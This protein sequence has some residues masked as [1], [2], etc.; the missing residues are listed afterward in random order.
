MECWSE[1]TLIC[2]VMFDDDEVLVS[3]PLTPDSETLWRWLSPTIHHRMESILITDPWTIVLSHKKPHH[4]RVIYH[5]QLQWLSQWQDLCPLS[6]SRALCRVIT[7][8]CKSVRLSPSPPPVNLSASGNAMQVWG[9][10]G[11]PPPPHLR[12]A[13]DHL[14]LHILC[15]VSRYL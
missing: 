3:L 12:T 1:K 2:F 15:A 11:P 7:P 13:S 6:L 5:Q 10:P 4:R 8:D 9:F 14:C